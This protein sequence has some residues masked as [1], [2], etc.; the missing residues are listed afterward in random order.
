MHVAVWWCDACAPQVIGSVLCMTQQ[1]SNSQEFQDNRQGRRSATTKFDGMWYPLPTRPWPGGEKRIGGRTSH[2][3]DF[4]AIE[5]FLLPCTATAM[6]LLAVRCLIGATHRGQPWTLAVTLPYGCDGLSAW[7]IAVLWTF[8]ELALCRHAR[9]EFMCNELLDFTPIIPA[10][11]CHYGNYVETDSRCRGKSRQKVSLAPMD[12]K[13][14]RHFP[15]PAGGYPSPAARSEVAHGIAHYGYATHFPPPLR[16]QRRVAA[17]ARRGV[18]RV[19]SASP[20]QLFACILLI[21]T[22]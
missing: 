18:P 2:R 16:G 11:A 14:K 4:E 20:C 19:S 22:V 1:G 9:R 21:C 10:T 8:H 7:L 3:T 12:R 17:A 15:A 5:S 13:N 6:S